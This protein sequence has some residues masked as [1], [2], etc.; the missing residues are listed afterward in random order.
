MVYSRRYIQEGIFKK[1]YSR[2]YIQEGIF[3]KVYS[4]RYIQRFKG[5]ANAK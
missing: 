5:R 3:K 4:R 1:V 2:R